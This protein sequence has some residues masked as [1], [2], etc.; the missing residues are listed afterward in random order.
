MEKRIH[1]L[2]RL[3]IASL[4]LPLAAAGC[5][6]R[7]LYVKSDPPGARVYL[8]HAEVG[9]TPLTHTFYHYGTYSIQ[10]KKEGYE[11]FETR[12]E[13]QGPW[14]EHFPLDFLFEVWPKRIAVERTVSYTLQETQTYNP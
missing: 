9:V 13:I 1:R 10:L 4:I 8:N 6:E 2:Q 5:I 7:K 14:Y 11:T 3:L 12:A